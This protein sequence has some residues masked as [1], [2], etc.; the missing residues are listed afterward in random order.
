MSIFDQI[1]GALGGPQQAQQQAQR[2]AN[3][4]A[5]L[6]DPNSRDFQNWS[7][8][9]GSAPPQV[10]QQA[11]TQAAQQVDPQE[12]YQHVTP[13]VGGTDPLGGLGQGALSTIAGTL[14]NNLGGSSGPGGILGMIPGL[15]ATNPQQMG[16]QDVA[17][18]ASYMQQNHPQA[19]GQAAA[20]IGQQQP[21]L[22]HSLLGNKALML[23]A[24][25]IGAKVL[26]DRSQGRQW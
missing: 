16:P 22:L 6:Q 12:Y 23:A 24:A 10:T 4:Q 14:M 26:Q 3:G 5:N 20:Q 9:V 8:M 15:Q 25:G 11:F 1:A 2:F 18:L 19:F 21:D 7:Q 17:Q 13:G